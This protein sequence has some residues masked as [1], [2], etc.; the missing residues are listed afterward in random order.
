MLRQPVSGR[1]TAGSRRSPRGAC[2]TFTFPLCT[3]DRYLG[4]FE[5]QTL[6]TATVLRQT[7]PATYALALWTS[8]GK[9][10]GNLGDAVWIRRA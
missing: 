10:W 2:R 4:G 3:S 5:A 1:E 8:L 7:V 9:C 6:G